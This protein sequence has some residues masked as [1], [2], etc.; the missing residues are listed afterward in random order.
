MH[1][2]LDFGYLYAYRIIPQL[3]TYI[4]TFILR[5]FLRFFAKKSIF[6]SKQS[7]SKNAC[8]NIHFTSG[9]IREFGILTM[10]VMREDVDCH[11]A[12]AMTVG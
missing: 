2:N 8:I 12:L 11:A 1:K 3:S 5:S 10:A 9:Q 7:L 6:C 4:Y